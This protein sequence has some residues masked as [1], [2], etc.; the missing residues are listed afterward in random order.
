MAL[1]YTDDEIGRTIQTVEDM[2]KLDNTWTFVL[3]NSKMMRLRSSTMTSSLTIVT[4]LAAGSDSAVFPAAHSGSDEGLASIEIEVSRGSIGLLPIDHKGK[5]ASEALEC[6]EVSSC[7]NQRP[8]LRTR[9][10]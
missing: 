2:G 8:V 9:S 4:G 3:S 5:L 10:V 7:R 6:R 1:A